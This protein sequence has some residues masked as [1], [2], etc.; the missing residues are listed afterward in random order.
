M[1]LRG[2][3]LRGLRGLGI[4]AM[5][6]R[7]NGESIVA[8]RST[9]VR[10]PTQTTTVA[11]P[12]LPVESPITAPKPV[13][14]L[15][16]QILP[17]IRLPLPAGPTTTGIPRQYVPPV[18][19]KPPIVRVPPLPIPSPSLPPAATTGTPVPANYPTS[20][21]FVAT[22]GSL[23]QYSGSTGKWFNAGTPYGPSSGAGT[24]STSP[25][26]PAGVSPSSSAPSS[27]VN[28]TVAPASTD[29]GYQSIIDWL[30]QSTLAQSVGFNIPNWITAGALGLLGYK[31]VSSKGGR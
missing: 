6:I 24:V 3:N 2:A 8:P 9:M 28:V 13:A 5:Q 21:L 23:W 25:A 17:V 16:S 1:Y 27:P 29:S 30:T 19:S 20:Q 11:R 12:P 31:L 22:D 4:T 26:S 7:T 14:V 15:P 10:V 18:I